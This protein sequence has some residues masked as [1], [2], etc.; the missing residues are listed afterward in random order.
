MKHFKGYGLLDSPSGFFFRSFFF[1]W[2]SDL[3]TKE[4]VCV[5]VCA[6]EI[7]RCLKKVTEGVEIFEDIW[8][9]VGGIFMLFRFKML[10]FL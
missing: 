7:D 9:K 10:L 8:K 5:C 4:C 2:Q 3:E 1:S 6:G